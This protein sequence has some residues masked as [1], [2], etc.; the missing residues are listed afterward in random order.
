MATAC[1]TADC[2]RSAKGPSVVATAIQTP[3][4]SDSQRE[5]EILK[6]K[7][8][9]VP[10][11]KEITVTTLS[12]AAEDALTALGFHVTHLPD[13]E[14]KVTAPTGGAQSAIDG[15]IASNNGRVITIYTQTVDAGGNVTQ[16]SNHGGPVASTGA[17]GGIVHAYAAGGIQLKPMRGGIAQI[18]APNTWRVIGDRVRDDEA[19]IPIND[20]RRSNT[21][22]AETA[23]RMGYALMRRYAGGGMAFNGGATTS[24]SPTPG[25]STTTINNTIHAA[26]GQS[27]QEIGRIASDRIAWDL[28]RR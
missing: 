15:F 18:V 24:A 2:S 20:S 27:P 17:I 3:G 13:G 21:L 12:Q 26:P 23:S 19:Y 5:L 14:V 9:A 1:S 4:M 22:L 10:G 8:D 11:S 28:R 7:F 16:R 25:A 6:G